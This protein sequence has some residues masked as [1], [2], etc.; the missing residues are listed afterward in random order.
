MIDFSASGLGLQYGTV[1]LVPSA[2]GWATIAREL[3]KDIG[4][5]LADSAQAVE[6]I[7]STTV[8]GLLAKPIIDLAVGLRPGTVVAEITEPM[9]QLRWIYRGDAGEDGG[10]VFVMEDTPWHR[11][12]HAHAVEY[13]GAQWVKYLAFRQLLCGNPTARHAYEATKARSAE[14]HPDG[15]RGYT[16]RKDATVQRLLAGDA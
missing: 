1:R 4:V 11:V 12:A 14:E 13:G 6:H 3:A 9:S 7:G 16:M 5:A 15:G 8:P 2:A 10:W